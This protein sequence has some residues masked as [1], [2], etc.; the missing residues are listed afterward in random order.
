ML[1]NKTSSVH[2]LGALSLACVAVM[3]APALAAEPAP[4]AAIAPAGVGQAPIEKAAFVPGQGFQVN[5]KPFFPIMLYSAK[6]SPAELAEF[7]AKGYNVLTVNKAEDAKNAAEAGFYIAQH[8]Y[9]KTPPTQLQATLFGIAMD[10]PNVNYKKDT[11]AKTQEDLA[12]VQKMIPDRPVFNAIGY[13]YNPADIDNEASAVSKN[14]LPEKAHYEDIINTIDVSAPYLY[15]VPYQSVT[16]VGDAVARARKAS[17]GKKAVLPVLQ[18]FTWDVKD[19]YPTTDELRAMVWLAVAA[20]ADG[21]GYYDYSYVTGKK[22][23][24]IAAE[25]PDLWKQAGRL[26]RELARFFETVNGGADVAIPQQEGVFTR[27]WKV[28]DGYVVIA[29]NTTDEKKTIDIA[30]LAKGK[31]VKPDALAYIPKGTDPVPKS[32]LPLTA[33]QANPREV[34]AFLIGDVIMK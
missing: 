19:R 13:W 28:G 21:I 16:T 3:A 27:A 17:G 6:T 11:L 15:P 25:Q 32:P 14:L 9:P 10:S 7:R 18:M 4:T 26:N 33:G 22:N 30:A 34:V 31:K 20:G 23:T 1:A 24:N 8:A 12:K 2:L 5:G 29:A